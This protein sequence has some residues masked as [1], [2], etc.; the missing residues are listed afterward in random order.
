[1]HRRNFL[2]GVASISAL[3][4]GMRSALRGDPRAHSQHESLPTGPP[5]SPGLNYFTWDKLRE[6]LDTSLSL[7]GIQFQAVAYNFP[8]WHPTPA[9]EKFMGEGWSEWQTLKRAQ[10]QF[11]G[12]L[13]P[14][15]PLWGY[16]NEA[17]PQWAELEI[18]TAANAGIDAFMVDWYWHEGTQFLHEQL[19]Q[20]F[21]KARNRDKLKFAIMWANHDWTNDYPIP[22]SNHPAI[23]YPQLY[24]EG[25]MERV[26]EYLIEHYISQKNYWRIG[27]LPVLAIYDPT[28]MLAFFG[29]EKLRKIFDKMRTRVA[30]AGYNGL[31]LQASFVYTPG[32]TPLKELGFDSATK[33]ISA[34]PHSKQVPYSSCVESGI[35][36]WKDTA[37]KVKMP[38]FPDCNVGWDNSPRG[39][40][41]SEMCID[42][43]PDQF[44]LYM[45]AAKYFLAEHKTQPPIVF[46]STWNEW[47]EDHCLLPD[48][49]YGYSYLQA[50]R[51]QFRG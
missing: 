21:L 41:T 51:R 5:L 24:S 29:K 1:M 6:V 44:E 33:Y 39:G 47:T 50:V 42:R 15:R 22:E 25:D 9:L 3:T 26:I 7:R 2:S 14:K 8:G 10:P 46:L 16:F 45:L 31:H 36:D 49:T 17:D 13:Q 32:E 20:G 38:F 28:H 18:E 23:W 27:N 30:S 40:I 37:E 12:H 43:S 34:F 35:G 48:T 19:E 11:P 4:L